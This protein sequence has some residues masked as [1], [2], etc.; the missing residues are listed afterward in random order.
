MNG[1]RLSL[2]GTPQDL[3]E[4]MQREA[5]S[6]NSK[7]SMKTKMNSLLLVLA[8]LALPYPICSAAESEAGDDGSVP[9]GLESS[10]WSGIRAAHEKARHAVEPQADGT[11]SAR[12][13]A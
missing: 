8:L 4:T 13:S 7:I 1:K 12:N 10:D 9:S 6:L 11:L 3:D 2:V 5:Y